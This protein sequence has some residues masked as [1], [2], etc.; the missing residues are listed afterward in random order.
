M[1]HLFLFVIRSRKGYVQK[2]AIKQSF[3]HKGKVVL[4]ACANAMRNEVPPLLIA[5]SVHALLPSNVSQGTPETKY[6]ILGVKWFEGYFLQD[7][8]NVRP[9]II[10]LNSHSDHRLS[11]WIPI[12]HTSL[13]LLTLT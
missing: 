6:S 13:N 9:Q 3:K 1:R 10:I 5:N 11:F 8:G 7:C 12:A 2:V 4:W